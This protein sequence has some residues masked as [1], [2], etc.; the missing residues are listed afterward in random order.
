MKYHI[1]KAVESPM[2]VNVKVTQKELA[3]AKRI[4][5]IYVGRMVEK[6]V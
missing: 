4:H 2:I 3:I 6:L 1:D 5:G